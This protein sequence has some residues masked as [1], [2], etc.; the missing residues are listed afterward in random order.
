MLIR[1]SSV[2]LLN[3][4]GDIDHGCIFLSNDKSNNITKFPYIYCKLGVNACVYLV[5]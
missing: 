1:C 4:G 2:H 5:D 3:G